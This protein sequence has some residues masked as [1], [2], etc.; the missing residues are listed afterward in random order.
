MSKGCFHRR[1]GGDAR[2]L[3]LLLFWV[4]SSSLLSLPS[5]TLRSP[6]S[7]R[8]RHDAHLASCICLLV[9]SVYLRESPDARNERFIYLRRRLIDSTRLWGFTHQLMVFLVYHLYKFDHFRSLR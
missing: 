7:C 3:V 8:C 2:Y 9:V 1:Q 4:L 5:C 6:S